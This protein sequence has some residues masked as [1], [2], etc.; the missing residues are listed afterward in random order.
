[1]TFHYPEM[2][3][4]KAQHGREEVLEGLRGAAD[5]ASRIRIPDAPY[6]LRFDFA[7][8]VIV[9]WLPD[10]ADPRPRSSAYAKPSSP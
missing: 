7:D 10:D 4:E 3:P 6:D 1:M 5:K 8:E 2:H 9:E